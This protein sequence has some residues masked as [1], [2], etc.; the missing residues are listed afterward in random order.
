MIDVH[1]HFSPEKADFSRDT[2]LPIL[3]LILIP[4]VVIFRLSLEEGKRRK[5][6]NSSIY[7]LDR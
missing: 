4:M 3:I 2:I 7:L 5:T 6:G 1:K